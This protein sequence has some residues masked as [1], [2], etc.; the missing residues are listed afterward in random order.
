MTRPVLVWFGRDL[1]LDDHPALACL[2]GRPAL[3]VYAL[4]DEGR[5]LGGAARWWL[6]HSLARLGA[7]IAARGGR[8]DILRGSSERWI[9]EVA[10][11]AGAAE[12]LWGRRYG[13]ADV[14]R[15][16]RIKAALKKQAI[17]ARSFNLSLLREPWEVASDEGR[18][19]RVFTPFWRR[20]RTLGAFPAPVAPPER[21]VAAPW[22]ADAPGRVD[23]DAL[24]LRPQQP[25]GS[26]GLAAAWTPGERGAEARMREFLEGSL[27]GYAE[28]R[29]RPDGDFTSRLSPHLAFGELSPRRLFYAVE[30]AIAADGGLARDGE[31]FLSELGWR[32]FAH[33]QLYAAPDLATRAWAEKFERFPFLDDEAGFRAWTQGATGYPFVDAGMRQLRAT[34][35]MH[36]R[37]RM[38][39]ASFLVKHL[40]V[41]WRHGESWF[42]DS[43]CDADAANNPAGWQWVAG[44]GADAAP[45]FRIFNPVLQG[46]K[47]DPDGD[48]VRRWVPELAELSAKAVHA[49]WRAPAEEL[50][51]AGIVLGATYPRPIV[52]HDFARR[53]A[54]AALAT[55][56]A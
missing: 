16:T 37:V 8:L 1:R 45:Y 50:A 15:L 6:S 28:A 29:D 12:V 46:E 42:W 7:D 21:L 52:D 32:E 49:P 31:K 3:F 14:A 5:T 55:I 33:A 30:A 20:H 38:V 35:W 2:E 56:S 34:G 53:R 26:G 44:S 4:D 11:A 22:P 51:R 19:Y 43:L 17:A 36:N 54:L 41:D 48:Y 9:P 39:A 47:F 13:G 24:R 25:D 18:P 23:L 10:R 27:A 40:L